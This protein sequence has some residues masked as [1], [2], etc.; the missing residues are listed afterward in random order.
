M[1]TNE[2]LERQHYRRTHRMAQ[3]RYRSA[4]RADRMRD[5]LLDY[6]RRQATAD[7]AMPDV[8]EFVPFK[9]SAEVVQDEQCQYLPTVS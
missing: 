3:E 4:E 1:N 9:L 5:L 6:Q 8:Q 7:Q 2:D